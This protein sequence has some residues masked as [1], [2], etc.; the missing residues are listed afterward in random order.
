MLITFTLS[1]I[2]KLSTTRY[3]VVSTRPISQYDGS[4]KHEL[5]PSF[6]DVLLREHMYI[7]NR[8]IFGNIFQLNLNKSICEWNQWKFW[9]LK[10]TTQ[11]LGDCSIHQLHFIHTYIYHV[12]IALCISDENVFIYF[13]FRLWRICPKLLARYWHFPNI[14]AEK[15]SLSARSVTEHISYKNKGGLKESM[16]T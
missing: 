14:I 12:N 2:R 11:R 13:S 8:E 4:V 9:R 6:L 3:I 16:I 1:I 7:A 15:S 10:V 5:R